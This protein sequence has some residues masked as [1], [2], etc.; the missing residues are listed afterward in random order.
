VVQLATALA[1]TATLTGCSDPVQVGLTGNASRPTALID[2]CRPNWFGQQSLTVLDA[3]TE[4]ALWKI[5]SVDGKPVDLRSV[6]FAEPPP[7]MKAVIADKPLAGHRDVQWWYQTP[8][9]E[10]ILQTFTLARLEPNQVLTTDN[11]LHD[12]AEWSNCTN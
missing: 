8:G 7:G 11:T 6:T 12:A 5:Q 1:L 10:P 9:D 4:E 2:P 3:D